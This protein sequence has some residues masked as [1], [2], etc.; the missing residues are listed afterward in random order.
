ME[1]TPLTTDHVKHIRLQLGLPDSA[2][3]PS[4]IQGDHAE[5]AET[6]VFSEGVHFDLSYTP[7]EHLARKLFL[8]MRGVFLA[9]GSDVSKLLITICLPNR[10]P[11]EFVES[12]AAG[13]S[14]SFAASGTELIQFRIQPVS[15]PATVVITALGTQETQWKKSPEAGDAICVTGSLGAAFAGLR[16]LSREKERM[17][18]Q[19]DG[20]FAT[21]LEDYEA[22]VRKQLYPDLSASL[23]GVLDKHSQSIG[24]CWFL[25]SSLLETLK[26]LNL[27]KGIM[28]DQESLP[29][30][31]ETKRVA[32]E[33]EESPYE[34]ALRGGE[35]F[36]FLFLLSADEVENVRDDYPEFRVI[37]YVEDGS[38]LR[39]KNLDGQFDTIS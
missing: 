7:P 15:G 20:E 11:K 37:G 25:S 14:S 1:F 23:F 17:A 9:F 19:E 4:L 13:L 39:V 36:E 12:F 38:D 28:I 10:I 27:G 8:Q 2:L 34:F 32:A 16:V 21:A 31:H 24:G 5:I 30:D 26:N 29:V 6:L 35:D 18:E 22:V 3:A 33:F